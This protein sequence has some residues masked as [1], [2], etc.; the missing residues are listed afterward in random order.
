MKRYDKLT[1]ISRDDT[2]RG[3]M[4][5][6]LCQNRMALDDILAVSRGMIVLFPEPINPKAGEILEQSGLVR[7]EHQAKPLTKDEFDER[8]LIL[9]ME[10]EQCDKILEEYADCAKNVYTLTGYCGASG[11]VKS[12]LGK[13]IEEYRVCYEQ[14]AKLIERL[15]MILREQEQQ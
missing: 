13:D 14:L 5:E 8:T 11:D 10:Q 4:A 6:A 15:A 7:E 2:C 9:T 3:P 12:P 1:F